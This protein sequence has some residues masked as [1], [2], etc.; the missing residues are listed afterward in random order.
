MS[1]GPHAQQ[2]ARDC[3]Q[4]LLRERTLE[5]LEGML[6]RDAARSATEHHYSW[7]ESY[8]ER[9][10]GKEARSEYYTLLEEERTRKPAGVNYR[11]GGSLEE[12]PEPL[13][14]ALIHPSA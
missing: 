11:A 9:L 5:R 8:V 12:G 6:R 3:Q 14:F 10:E 13:L 2:K 1:D 7:L 4:E